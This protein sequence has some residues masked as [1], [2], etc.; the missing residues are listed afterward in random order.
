MSNED[1]MPGA[2]NTIN[3]SPEAEKNEYALHADPAFLDFQNVE[4]TKVDDT[5]PWKPAVEVKV[6]KADGTTVEGVD[7]NTP[8][9][10]FRDAEGNDMT[11]TA[12]AAGHIDQLHIKGTDAGSK[13]DYPS[14]KELF[15]D[16][17][18]KLPSEIAKA[19]GVSDFAID[20]GKNMGKEGIATMA[21]LE[22]TGELT[23]EN[24]DLAQAVRSKVQEL[25]KSGDENAK[26][27]FIE[28]WA[29]KHPDSKIKFEL[30]RGTVLVPTV[31]APK[32]DTQELF[33]VF[34][35]GAD[36]KKTAYT[37]APGRHMPR[38]PNP[39]QHKNNE[40]ALDEKTFQESADA[41]FDTVMLKGK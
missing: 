12:A 29:S 25:N 23:K 24:I 28:Q 13:F 21:E 22:K 8:F 15:E 32:R 4:V 41:W 20:M 6:V 1:T 33:M 17:A 16:V 36:G 7:A 19:P 26:K 30:I 5:K 27:A 10:A 40:G 34:G 18:K 14:L 37:M 35:P 11:V 39:G 38:H 9:F 2:D 31:D 3:K